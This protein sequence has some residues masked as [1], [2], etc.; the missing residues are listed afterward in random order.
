[1]SRRI[2]ATIAALVSGVSVSFG[3]I[4]VRD[5]PFPDIIARSSTIRPF[6]LNA[7][8]ITLRG[9]ITQEATHIKPPNP[10]QYFRMAVKDESAPAG[11]T[12]WAVLL[13]ATDSRTE[14]LKP[15]AAVSIRATPSKDGSR[16]VELVQ[17]IGETQLSGVTVEAR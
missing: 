4:E 17:A 13:H 16:R 2:L 7:P 11:V 1:M 3:Q 6:D 14:V 9:V 15:G 5:N 12:I 8:K 10:Y